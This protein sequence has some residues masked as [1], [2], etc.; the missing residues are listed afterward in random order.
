MRQFDQEWER[1][2]ASQ[3]RVVRWVRI[4][5]IAKVV[6]GLAV[7]GYVGYLSWLAA[8]KFLV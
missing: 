8:Q 5:I 6:I 1:M 7:L 4:M 2:R 3:Q